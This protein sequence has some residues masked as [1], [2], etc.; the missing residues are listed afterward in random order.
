MCRAL[1]GKYSG[2][3]RPELPKLLPLGHQCSGHGVAPLNEP[4]TVVLVMIMLTT[5]I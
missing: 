1:D 4:G 3:L 5:R 2:T